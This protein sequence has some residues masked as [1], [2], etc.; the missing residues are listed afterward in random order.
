MT[1]SSSD[2]TARIYQFPA[3]ARAPVSSGDQRRNDNQSVVDLAMIRLPKIALG[4]C[5]YH[6]EAVQEAERNQKR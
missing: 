6:D 4:G 2:G 5:W 3:R 1:S